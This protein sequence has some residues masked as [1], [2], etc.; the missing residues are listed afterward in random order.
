M[1]IPVIL[2]GGSGSRLWPLSRGLYPKQLLSLV[3]EHTLLQNTLL[4]LTDFTGICDP[5]V[6]CNEEH[7][8]M[9]AEQLRAIEVTAATIMLEPVGRNTAPALAA[10][11][12]AAVKGG[13]DPL[14]LVLPADHNIENV[15]AFHGALAHGKAFALEDHLI[16]FGVVPHSPETGYGYIRKGAPLDLADG[17][18]WEALKIAE[19]VEKPDLA[20]AETYLSGG[21]YLWNS[22]MFLFKA[23]TVLKELETYVPEIVHA[24]R[25]AVAGGVSDLD[26]FRLDRDAFEA[27]PSDSIDYAL[28]ERTRRG[29]MVPLSADWTDLGSW[30]SL[31]QAGKKDE[32]S[33]VIQGDVITYDV[34]NSFLSAESRMLA[35]VGLEDHVVVETAD[36]VLISPRN[37][38]Q[39]VKSIVAKLKAGKRPEAHCHRKVYRPWGSYENVDIS[40]RFQVKRITVKPGGILSLQKHYHRAEHWTVVRGVAKVTRGE[41]VFLLHE[42]HSTYIP[43][44][45]MHRLENPGK[46]PLELIEVQ[47][48][49]YLGEDD[50]ERFEDVYGR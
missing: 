26:F 37:R 41:E 12:I 3:N 18:A 45:T 15:P 25:K 35:A 6:I 22:G 7:R 50:I 16:T 24:C 2:S 27:C 39:E 5:I 46:I 14:L 49:S 20:T 42:D 17:G 40:K 1:I 32:N 13:E 4:R 47:S 9:V 10:A 21:E 8:F 38:V 28:M 44:G 31:W 34:S 23:S 30:D 19:F 11:A 29:A 33:N 36:A 43:L 48:G